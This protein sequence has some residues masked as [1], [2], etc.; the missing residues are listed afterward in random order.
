MQTAGAGRRADQ[1]PEQTA[2]RLIAELTG[3]LRQREDAETAVEVYKTANWIIS[4]LEEVKDAARD[5]AQSDMEQRGLDKLDT[6]TGSAGWTE[7]Q[8]RQ[9]DEEAWARALTRN[10]RLMEIQREFERAKR[11]LE[12]AQEPFR[13]LPPSRFYVR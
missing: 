6:P 13:E 1:S 4:Q 3:R 11:E 5:L 10:R 7:P 8:V 9:L 2:T 12:R